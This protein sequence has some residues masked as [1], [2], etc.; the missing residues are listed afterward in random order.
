[1]V[2]TSTNLTILL[3]FGLFS[4]GYGTLSWG[5]RVGT[6]CQNEL[7]IC[8]VAFLIWLPLLPEDDSED[9]LSGASVSENRG[10]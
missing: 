2:D 1:M 8:S 5:L 6:L 10:S 7:K 4:P 3:A 9:F